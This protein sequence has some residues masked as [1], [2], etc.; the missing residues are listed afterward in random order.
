[1]LMMILV[2]GVMDRLAVVAVGRFAHAQLNIVR[3]AMAPLALG[4]V[5]WIVLSEC[6]NGMVQVGVYIF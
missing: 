6:N 5:V 2:D 1:M 4:R 3:P